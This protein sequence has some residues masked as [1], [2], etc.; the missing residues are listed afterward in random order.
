MADP[1]KSA[2]LYMMVFFS[3]IVVSNSGIERGSDC[4]VEFNRIVR[5]LKKR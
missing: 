4:F 3:L 2:P 1:E 5:F